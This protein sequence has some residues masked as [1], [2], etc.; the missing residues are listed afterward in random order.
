MIRYGITGT[1]T[2]VGKTVVACALIAALRDRGLSVAGMKPVET[3]FDV[4]PP[5]ARQLWDAAG[6]MDALDD[7][8]PERFHEPLA[9]YLAARRA[10]RTISIPALDTARSRLESGRDALVVEGAG[11]LL[12][13]IADGMAFDT[14]FRRWDLDCIVVAAN[15]LGA[16]N[17][18]LLTV[19]AARA[20]GLRVPAVVLN[21]VCPPEPTLAERTNLD[22]LRELIPDA[23]IL[24]FPYNG[25]AHDLRDIC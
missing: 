8:C 18:T 3:G 14:L 5:D 1:D 19:R 20:A 12:V 15:R 4:E 23:K 24:P 11:G 17:H 25:G 9:P 2:G 16:I 10:G 6:R 7:V 21:T 22:T 13:M